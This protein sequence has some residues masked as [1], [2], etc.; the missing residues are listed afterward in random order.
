MLKKI[1]TY[2][3]A[4]FFAIQFI[5]MSRTNKPVKTS[6]NLADLHEVPVKTMPVLKKA[7]YDCHSNE[8]KYPSYAYIAPFSWS[9]KSHVNNGR[10]YMNMSEW[11]NYNNDQKKGILEKSIKTVELGTMPLPAYTAWHPE[12]NLTDAEKLMLIN[13]F[14]SV[15]KAEKL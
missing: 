15:Q 7:C 5:P 13:Y 2:G 3:L 11:A 4:A 14:Q 12:A 1:I 6:E 9:L 10:R 8:T